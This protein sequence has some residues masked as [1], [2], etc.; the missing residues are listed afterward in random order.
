MNYPLITPLRT[1]R[2][3]SKIMNTIIASNEILNGILEFEDDLNPNRPGALK[4]DYLLVDSTPGEVI[5]LTLVSDEFNAYLQLINSDTGEV[6]TEND[7][8]Y[9]DIN[10]QLYFIPEENVNYLVRVTSY[11]P[12]ETG[13]Y[14]LTSNLF[15]TD[16]DLVVTDAEAIV[17]YYEKYFD[18]FSIHFNWTIT[19]LGL[20]N[21]HGWYD[22][23]YLSSDENFDPLED[24]W[25]DSF[26]IDKNLAAGKSYTKSLFTYLDNPDVL[27]FEDHYLIFVTDNYDDQYENNE[28]NNTFTIPI[29]LLPDVDLVV[30]DAEATVVSYDEYNDYTYI[31]L[32]WTV[33]NLGLDQANNLHNIWLDAVY[34]SSDENF[35]PLEDYLILEDYDWFPHLN[36]DKNLAAGESYTQYFTTE[37]Y[38]PDVWEFENHYLIF[39][40]ND[41]EYQYETN[42]NNNTF[43]IPINLPPDWDL[44]VTDAEVTV[45]SYEEDSDSAYIDINWTVTNLGL[46]HVNGSYGWI[47][48]VYFSSDEN[49]DPLED[50]WI[51]NFWYGDNL[52][53]GESYTQYFSTSIH[54]RDNY[55][56]IFVIDDLGDQYETNENNNTFTIPL[57][58]DI[59]F[60]YNQLI[61]GSDRNDT[62]AGGEGDD[63]LNG[64]AG[65][66]KL[67]GQNGNDL[68][69]GGEG[70]DTLRGGIGADKLSG[71][72]GNDLLNGGEGHDTLAGG[73]GLDSLKGG[74][75]RDHFRLA[76][77]LTA[78]RDL[79]LDFEDGLDVFE[80]ISFGSVTITQVG[81]DTNI[82]QTNTN[83]TL[84][85]LIGIDAVT[86]D[87]SDFV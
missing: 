46:D 22:T 10:S 45:I 65:A 71:Q 27:E 25:I 72:N 18:Q 37:I 87:S 74:T 36:I 75:G 58:L 24:Y 28:N 30:T 39:V 9:D 31:D 76:S 5:Q 55:Y 78:D 61:N 17:E 73:L 77:G 29:N 42:K 49:F 13:N 85:T 32:N 80:D 86:I 40:T 7:Y 3:I 44:V 1:D 64:G 26:W 20:D 8:D 48:K 50:Y 19:N 11:S 84:A 83:Q 79:I 47:D 56:L 15:D 52:A 43:T 81:A 82:I 59:F 23:V 54:N 62:L 63:T 67:S 14:T 53:A 35:D 70:H 60:Y 68:L 12:A 2:N 51:D 33:T 41:H 4:D 16:V 69:N 34:L 66:D 21:A 57:N 6:I 38:N